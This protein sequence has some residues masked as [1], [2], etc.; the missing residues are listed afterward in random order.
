[1]NTQ[2]TEPEDDNRIIDVCPACAGTG[3][4]DASYDHLDRYDDDLPDDLE[5]CRR[6]GGTGETDETKDTY[7]P[8]SGIRWYMRMRERGFGPAA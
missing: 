4:E 3:R 2:T 6:C 7:K 5:E 8:L 1:M